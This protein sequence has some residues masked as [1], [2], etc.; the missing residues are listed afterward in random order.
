MCACLTRN[1]WSGLPLAVQGPSERFTDERVPELATTGAYV[2]WET[3]LLPSGGRRRSWMGRIGHRASWAHCH[4][5]VNGRM[6]WSDA[7][8]KSHA[9]APACRGID[10]GPRTVLGWVP[11]TVRLGF[12]QKTGSWHNQP[13]PSS[14]GTTNPPHP[15]ERGGL[16]ATTPSRL[17]P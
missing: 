11:S 16:V 9:H 14:P 5:S 6:G 17:T 3:G 10:L 7:G 12:G 15:E 2:A 1:V 8:M 13:A 4:L